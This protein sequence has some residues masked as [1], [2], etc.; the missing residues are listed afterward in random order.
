MKTNEEILTARAKLITGRRSDKDDPSGNDLSVIEFM[1]SPE[2]YAVEEQFVGE[3]LLLKELTPIPGV[4]NYVT[5]IANIRGRIISILN[6]KM[7][8]GISSKGITELN[9]IIILKSNRMEFGILADSILGSRSFPA[10]QLAGKPVTLKGDASRYVKGI[11]AEGL[12]LLDCA[13]LLSDKS[14]TINQKQK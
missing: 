8:L 14:I 4:P 7:L 1:L 10:G 12:V 3:V 11:T 6:L 5:G 2:R 13:Q 9:R